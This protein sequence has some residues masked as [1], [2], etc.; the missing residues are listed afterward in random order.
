MAA[1]S[2]DKLHDTLEQ[3]RNCQVP[4]GKQTDRAGSLPNANAATMMTNAYIF[5]ML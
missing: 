1:C 2:P 3:E 4:E 5:A